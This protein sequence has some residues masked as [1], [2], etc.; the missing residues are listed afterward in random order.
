[1]ELKDKVALV[2]SATRGIGFASALKLAEKGATVYLGVRR[3]DDTQEICD[4]YPELKM[5]PVYF[6]AYE[7]ET[8]KSMIDTIIEKEGKLDILVNNFGTSTPAKDFDLVN[9]DEEYFFGIIKANVG[10]V[11]SISKNAVPH[12]IKNGGGSIVNISSIGGAIP[13]ISRIAYG[14]SKSA[15]NNL[16]QQMAMQYARHGVRVNAV[17]PGLTATDAALDNMPEDFRKSFLSHV[18]LNRM[19]TPEDMANA[20]YFFASDLSSYITGDIMEVA[21][22]YGLGTPQYADYVGSKVVGK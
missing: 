6:N 1:M 3:M 19:G 5:I 18:P 9:T 12:M 13:D 21:G 22:G 20:V 2:T 10:T 14:V 15:V 8:Y 11:Y 7:E 17:L 4:K 16:T